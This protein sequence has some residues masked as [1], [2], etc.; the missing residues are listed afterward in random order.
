MMNSETNGSGWCPLTG[1]RSFRSGNAAWEGYGQHRFAISKRTFL[2]WVGKGKACPPR[3]DGFCHVE[4]IE[5]FSKSKAWPPAP[6]FAG[7]VQKGGE[8]GES[9]EEI[10]YGAMYQ[11]EK[12]LKEAILREKEEIS[13][14][15]M[16]GELLPRAEYEQ[17]LA[18]AAIVVGTAA[19]TWA[20][21]KARE[22]IHQCEGNPA[23]EDEVREFLLREVRAWLHA[24]SVPREY[25]VELSAAEAAEAEDDFQDVEKVAGFQPAPGTEGE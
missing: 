5:M 8:G 25:L 4:D 2:T 21:D 10:E 19:E 11:R 23:K 14:K 9:P 17:R 13:L 6:S 22:V 3:S 18:A 15:K 1:Q 12:A 7:G 24:F 20:Y 16:K